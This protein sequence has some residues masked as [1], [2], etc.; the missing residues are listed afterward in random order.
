MT[1]LSD[2]LTKEFVLNKA[3]PDVACEPLSSRILSSSM[4]VK[5]KKKKLFLGFTLTFSL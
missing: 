4:T 2:S 1:D 5:K 3:K